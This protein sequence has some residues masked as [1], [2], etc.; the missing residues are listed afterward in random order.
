MPTRKK[1]TKKHRSYLYSIFVAV[2]FVACFT[3]IPVIFPMKYRAYTDDKKTAEI[4]PPEIKKEEVPHLATP[5][6]MRAVYMTSCVAGTINFR[7]EVVKLVDETEVNSL[8]IDIK[9]FSGTLSYIPNDPALKE[10]LST[11]CYAPD[12]KEFIKKLHEKN[13]YVIGRVT[14]FQDP[15][16]TKKYPEYAVRK[17]SDKTT[18]H[19]HKGI[20]FIDVGARPAWDHIVAIAK[21]AYG[22][23]F[24]EINFDYVRF[25][26]DGNMKDIYFSWSQG[27]TKSDA[28]EEFFSYLHDSLKD[29]GVVTSADLFGMTTTN[30]DDL[31]IGQVLEKAL[32]YFDYIYPMVYPSHYPNGF[33]GWTNPNK[34]PYEIIK[35]SMDK[36]IARTVASSTTIAHKGGIPI[37]STTPQRYTKEV[38]DKNKI[39]PWIQDFDYG[40]NYDI[41]EVKAQIKAAYDAGLN[42]WLIWSPSNRY[43]RGALL[44][45]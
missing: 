2:I 35:F 31:N 37:A 30:Y 21:D 10:Y 26:S 16:Y 34:Y 38:Y 27:K 23:G 44:P 33:N 12:M 3:F 36:A 42:S 17:L 1:L 43:T 7:N 41:P 19:D 13:I 20:S 28:L 45:Q 11:R 6:P 5:V 39:R 14:V 18:W 9:D 24:D 15:F 25:P 32:P 4:A 22:I 29:T 8:I 40:G